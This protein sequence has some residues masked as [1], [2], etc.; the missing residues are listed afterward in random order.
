LGIKLQT[1]WIK[2]LEVFIKND[3][4]RKI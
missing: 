3:G 1:F 2:N 4:I